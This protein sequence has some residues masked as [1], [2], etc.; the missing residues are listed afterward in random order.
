MYLVWKILKLDQKKKTVI[1]KTIFVQSS[2][3]M[4]QHITCANAL[5]VVCQGLTMQEAFFSLHISLIKHTRAC[6]LHTLSLGGT[7]RI[8]AVDRE[9]YRWIDGGEKKQWSV[10]SSRRDRAFK[11]Q[12]SA[13]CVLSPQPVP[14]IQSE[15]RIYALLLHV[16][17]TR[18]WSKTYM[19]GCGWTCVSVGELLGCITCTYLCLMWMWGPRILSS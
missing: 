13:G 17:G 15:W 4:A 9:K 14:Y 18:Q 12:S 16:G 5:I 3:L 2:L 7:E 11:E 6:G 10:Y 8:E 1:N 19:C